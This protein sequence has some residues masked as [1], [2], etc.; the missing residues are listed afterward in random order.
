MAHPSDATLRLKLDTELRRVLNGKVES[1]IRQ[2]SERTAGYIQAIRD[3]VSIMNGGEIPSDLL[4]HT[5]T[6]TQEK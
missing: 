5:L 6:A 3:V 1:L 2:P 4:D